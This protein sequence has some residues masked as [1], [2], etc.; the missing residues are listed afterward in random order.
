MGLFFWAYKYKIMRL[1]E[2]F[3]DE[4]RGPKELIGYRGSLEW[5]KQNITPD[6]YGQYGVSLTMINKLGVNPR[7]TYNTPLGIY[8]YPLSFY[9]NEVQQGQRMPYPEDPKYIQIF[10]IKPESGTVLDLD[11]MTDKTVRGYVRLLRSKI[12]QINATVPEFAEYIKDVDIDQVIDDIVSDAP[13]AALVRT[14]GGQFW[15]ILY[16]LSTEVLNVP[17]LRKKSRR[18]HSQAQRSPV[19]WNWLSRLLGIS[20]YVDS[21]GVIHENEP[22]QGVVVDP[23]AI[24]LVKT[25]SVE[26]TRIEVDQPETNPRGLQGTLEKTAE[27]F[28]SHFT[29]RHFRTA[30]TKGD[31]F[32]GRKILNYLSFILKRS[33]GHQARIQDWELAY[34]V[35]YKVLHSGYAHPEVIGMSYSMAQNSYF[36]HSNRTQA[37]Y[38]TK[39]DRIRKRTEKLR[40]EAATVGSFDPLIKLVDLSSQ[41]TRV[42][43]EF[44]RKN[45]IRSIN[46]DRF[47]TSPQ[48]SAA[49]KQQE[50]AVRTGVQLKDSINALIVQAQKLQGVNIP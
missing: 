35:A 27:Q 10:R 40:S 50:E 24:E 20:A 5:I 8:F 49:L 2:L 42:T 4:K 48:V 9:V 45:S 29:N 26:D 15:Y 7:S 1:F 36:D 13:A 38:L 46:D 22:D 12:P 25:L 11:K 31:A 14:P 17:Y 6:Q 34:D 18:T 41:L 28:R 16:K 23:A 43:D 39:I 37:E 32:V 3:L 44:K 19:L 33:G 21:R 30:L 47:K